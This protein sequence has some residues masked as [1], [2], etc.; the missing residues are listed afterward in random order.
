MKLGRVYPKGNTVYMHI[1]S[2]PEEGNFI[3]V[4]ELKQKVQKAILF[5]GRKEV[6]IK[7][8]PEGTFIYLD[9]ITL[10]EMDTIIELQLN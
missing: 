3:F 10:D 2:K 8:L 1:L 4:P 5:D 7:Q 9:N 6:K